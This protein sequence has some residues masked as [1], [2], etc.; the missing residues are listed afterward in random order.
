MLIVIRP[1]SEVVEEG[2][3]FLTKNELEIYL[4]LQKHHLKLNNVELGSE[5]LK[6]K[7]NLFNL[8]SVFW[9]LIAIPS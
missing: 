7:V 4:T 2:R 3:I 9:A 6:T 5:S 8:L 1:S